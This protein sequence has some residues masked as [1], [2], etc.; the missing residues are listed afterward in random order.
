[1]F[2]VSPL[3]GDGAILPRG[4]ELRIFGTADEDEIIRGVIT[5]A[6][7]TVTGAG[8]SAARPYAGDMSAA[9]RR[10]QRCFA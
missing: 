5:A 10:I 7:G 3:F 1:M 8:E 6:D 2:K 4:K 9:D